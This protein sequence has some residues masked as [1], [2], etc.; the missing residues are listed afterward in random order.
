[1]GENHSL[2]IVIFHN[3]NPLFARKISYSF[4]IRQSILV[5]NSGKKYANNLK[6]MNEIMKEKNSSSDKQFHKMIKPFFNQKMYFSFHVILYFN[7]NSYHSKYFFFHSKEK[8]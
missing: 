1:M 7:A 5:S 3:S 4:I 2:E 6:I 8:K